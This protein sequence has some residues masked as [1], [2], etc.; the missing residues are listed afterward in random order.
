MDLSI[1]V[2]VYNSENILE[3]FV[4]VIE[5]SIDF[6]DE[7]ELVLVNDYSSDNSWNKIVELKDKYSFIKGVNLIKNY[8]QHNAVM[9]ALN[10]SSGDIIVTMD[11]DLQ[12]NPADIV[13]L[14]KKITDKNV[15]VCY[16][17]FTSREHKNWKVVG[18]QF[19]DLVANILIKKPKNLYLSPFRAMTKQIKDMIIQ[20]EG[21]YPYVD[22][23]ILSI[24]NNI[25][26]IEVE[27]SK[28]FEGEG[29]YNLSKSISLWTKMATGFS[30]IPLR[31][32]TY[33]GVITS[34]ISFVFLL[35]LI[36]Q[37]IVYDAMPDGWTSIMVL[38]L[39]FGG[40]QLFSLGLIGEYMGR[41][42]L[43]INKKAQYIIREKV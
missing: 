35:F 16:T 38:I 24:T 18:S 15:D 4:S 17:E 7:F 29:N 41:A 19:N 42:Y 9:A 8:S 34:G 6:V 40:V 27:H 14:Y 20:Y 3:K 11:D 37:K 32:A 30:V 25:T 39:F 31:F 5:D 33:L 13:K 23:L 21:P 26:V 2:P 1:C 10:E 43:N 12:H 36:F 28:R 22:G